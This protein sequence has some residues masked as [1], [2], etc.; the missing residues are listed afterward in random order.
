MDEL[1]EDDK[2]TVFRA[3]KIQKFFSQPF[4]VGEQ[5]TGMP[6]KYV[7]MQDTVKSFKAIVSGEYDHIPEQAF[8]WA[9]GIE[10]VLAKAKEIESK[11]G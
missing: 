6:G 7:S 9:G 5:F 8:A 10:D 1:S 2:V 4:F 3:R 11:N